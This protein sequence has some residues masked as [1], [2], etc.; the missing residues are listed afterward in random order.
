MSFISIRVLA[1]S[2]DE[3]DWRFWVFIAALLAF[4]LELYLLRMIE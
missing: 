4:S 2:S 1:A 3:S